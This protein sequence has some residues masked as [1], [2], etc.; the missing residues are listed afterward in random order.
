MNT[1]QIVFS[2]VDETMSNRTMIYTE[3]IKKSFKK[4]IFCIKPIKKTNNANHST[5]I[6]KT[7]SPKAGADPGIP[8]RVGGFCVLISNFNIYNTKKGQKP[9]YIVHINKK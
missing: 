2:N 5:N 9:K 6:Q 4:L 3:L 7:N 8:L 1:H